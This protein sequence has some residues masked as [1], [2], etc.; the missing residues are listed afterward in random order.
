ML[1]DDDKKMDFTYTDG[2]GTYS[3]RGV[4]ASIRFDGNYNAV[5]G[6]DPKKKGKPAPKNSL[7]TSTVADPAQSKDPIIQG[8]VGLATALALD[9]V[10]GV[11]VADDPLI[12]IVL[13]AT[14]IYA[15]VTT[16]FVQKMSN[17]IDRIAKKATGPIGYSYELRV[18]NAGTYIDVRGLPVN[19]NAGYIWK[20][21][22]ATNGYNR[23]SQTELRTMVPGGVRQNI[24]FVGNEVQIRIFEKYFIYGYYFNHGNL[25]PGNKIFR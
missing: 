4:S 10:S 6:D 7:P 15:A 11:G 2:Y 9:D 25:P 23:Y 8:G 16:D 20:Y 18:N 22:K 3:S 17:E 5:G 13:A 24:L 1:E 19:L 14:A 21:G 12:P